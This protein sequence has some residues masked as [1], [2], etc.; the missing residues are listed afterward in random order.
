MITRQGPGKV[1]LQND[2][3][4][5]EKAE[6]EGTKGRRQSTDGAQG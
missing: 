2:I 3:G 6:V 1:D 5:I 4:I